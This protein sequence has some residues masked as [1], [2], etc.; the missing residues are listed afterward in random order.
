[1]VNI[2][3]L[4]ELDADEGLA[5]YADGLALQLGS[6]GTVFVPRP[7]IDSRAR[8]AVSMPTTIVVRLESPAGEATIANWLTTVA[9][10]LDSGSISGKAEGRSQTFKASDRNTIE[11]LRSLIGSE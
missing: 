2:P 7:G 1:M 6:D 10:Q 3:V 4:L 9:G 5:P 11:T 8:S